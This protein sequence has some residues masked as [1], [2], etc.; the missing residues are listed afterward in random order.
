MIVS[1]LEGF[2]IS[3]RLSF[4]EVGK[5]VKELEKQI[6]E[7]KTNDHALEDCEEQFQALLN[8]TAGSALLIDTNRLARLGNPNRSMR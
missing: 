2:L 3:N 4:P 7:F 6:V 8:A 5:K 1:H